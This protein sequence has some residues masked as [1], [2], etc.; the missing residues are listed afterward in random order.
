MFIIPHFP[1]ILILQHSDLY[2]AGDYSIALGATLLRS[3]AVIVLDLHH[4]AN[5]IVS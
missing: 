5:T 4:I 1:Y 2:R 3:L